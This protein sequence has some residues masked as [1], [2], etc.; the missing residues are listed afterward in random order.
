MA[1]TKSRQYYSLF[2]LADFQHCKQGKFK[3]LESEFPLYHKATASCL[4]ALYFGKHELA[5]EHCNNI[6]IR[7][8]Y[9]P[10]WIHQKGMANFFVYSPSMPTI[11]I[12]VRL[13]ELLKL[14]TRKYEIQESCMKKTVTYFRRTSFCYQ[15]P[16]ETLISYSHEERQSWQTT[17]PFDARRSEAGNK[18][19]RR[20]RWDTSEPWRH[21]GSASGC[22]TSP[23]QKLRDLLLGTQHDQYK[24]SH[25][26]GGWNHTNYPYSL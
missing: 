6:I 9:K 17:G 2:T 18:S 4:G 20:G 7:K 25:F 21:C 22:E 26:A 23:R 14:V 3:I 12:F 16:A 15:L 13:K 5:H 1:V 10:V 24:T 11:N 19:P 8:D